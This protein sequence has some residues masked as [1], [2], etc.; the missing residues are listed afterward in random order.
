LKEAFAENFAA[1]EEIGACLAVFQGGDLLV[2]IWAGHSDRAKVEPWRKDTLVNV[3]SSGKA[4]AAMLVLML[5]D[6]GQLDLDTPVADYW[7]EFAAN[8][9]ASFTIRDAMTHRTGVPGFATPQPWDTPHNWERMT[10]LIA[11]EAPWFETRTLCY[12]PNTYGF[13]IGEIIRRVTGQNIHDFGEAELF[14]PLGADFHFQLDAREFGRVASLTHDDKPFPFEEG[15]IPDRAMS[16]VENP[17]EG[18]DIWET[19]ERMGAI[20]PGSN[21]YTNARS[22]AK[23]GSVMTA[24][25]TVGGVTRDLPG[26]PHRTG[27]R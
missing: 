16:S 3:Y 23:I 20:M 4:V 19:P 6:R 17:P 27:P 21:N 15:S 2:D 13:I 14:G 10:E 24:E 26:S 11:R 12:H 1:G 25:G 5:I 22:L 7:P 18:T 9:K 8:G